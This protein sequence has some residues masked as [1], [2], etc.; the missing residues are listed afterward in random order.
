MPTLVEG[1]GGVFDVAADGKVYLLN[2]R[3]TTTVVQVGEQPKV[4][5]VN[6]LGETMLATP[7][8]ANGAIY[9]R[10]DQHLY[11]IGAKEGE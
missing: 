2:E 7:A 11:C 3:G 9:L 6:A 10:S 1:R 4:L 8:I 5:A